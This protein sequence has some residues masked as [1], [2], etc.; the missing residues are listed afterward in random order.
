MNKQRWRTGLCTLCLAILLGV[1]SM[2]LAAPDLIGVWM[3]TAPK[4]TTAG[5]SNVTVNVSITQ[6]CTNQVSGNVLFAGNV[7]IGSSNPIPVTGKLTGTTTTNPYLSLNGYISGTTYSNVNLSGNYVTG[8][9]PSITV[10]SLYYS[11]NIDT[12][13]SSYD[14]LSLVKH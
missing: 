3:G 9:T 5:C 11:N 14:T 10:T 2:T 7:I 1:P 13:S 4:I 6:Q 8:T 12:Q